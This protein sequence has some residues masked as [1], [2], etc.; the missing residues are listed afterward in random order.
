MGCPESEALIRA[1]VDSP[2]EALRNT[3]QLRGERIA[4]F[5]GHLRPGS[6]NSDN[7]GTSGD[8]DLARTKKPLWQ[9]KESER[10]EP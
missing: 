5:Q 8:V 2:I 1:E 3:A 10:R 6:L 7:R 9:E 4:V